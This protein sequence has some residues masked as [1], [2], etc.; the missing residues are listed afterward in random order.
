MRLYVEWNIKFLSVIGLCFPNKYW[1]WYFSKTI[2]NSNLRS[3]KSWTAFLDK[4][5][6]WACFVLWC[7]K[8]NWAASIAVSKSFWFKCLISL[9]RNPQFTIYH[10]L[11]SRTKSHSFGNNANF[12]WMQ[13]FRLLLQKIQVTMEILLISTN[14]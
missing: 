11:C 3:C 6:I 5:C 13:G 10:C 8:L 2:K 4:T 9:I 1:Y 14:F 7:T 12:S